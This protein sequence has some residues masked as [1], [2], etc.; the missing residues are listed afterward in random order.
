MPATPEQVRLYRQRLRRRAIAAVC[1][2]LPTACFGCGDLNDLEFAHV[3]P[4]QLS[5]MSRGQYRRWLDVVRHP[6]RYILLCA[7]CHR[8]FDK[9]QRNQG[10]TLSQSEPIPD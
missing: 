4:T 2:M 3:R 8:E 10:Q 1:C 9:W 7:E 5:G 6:D